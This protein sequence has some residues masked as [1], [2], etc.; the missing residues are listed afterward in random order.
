MTDDLGYTPGSGASVATD[1]V[2]GRHYQRMKVVTG[3]D[4]SVTGDVSA[5][6]PMPTFD[7][8]TYGMMVRLFNL[9]KMPSGY[10]PSLNRARATVI[11]ESGTV[12]NISAGTITTV[13]TLSNVTNIGNYSAQ[14]AQDAWHRSAWF[15]MVR[16]RIT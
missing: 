1:N 16:V 2:G 12:S 5:A 15:D 8:N 9:L 10:D 13:S 7:E 4:G 6:N 3:A 11:V 14:Q